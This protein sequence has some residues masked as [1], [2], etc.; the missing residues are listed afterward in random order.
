MPFY[1][2]LDV[3]QKSTAICVVDERGQRHW[4]GVSAL[5]PALGI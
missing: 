5:M 1:V 3:S 2:G 4:R